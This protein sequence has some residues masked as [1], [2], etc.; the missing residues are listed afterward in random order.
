MFNG[1]DFR[2]G[3]HAEAWG[4]L[5]RGYTDR[6]LYRARTRKVLERRLAVNAS[7]FTERLNCLGKK[8]LGA[9]H[10]L[11]DERTM[12]IRYTTTVESGVDYNPKQFR[13]EVKAYLADPNGWKSEGYAFV[14]SRS[15]DVVIHL[16]SAE[17]LGQ[18]GCYDSKLSCAELGGRHM[19]LNFDRWTMGAPASKLPL[20]DYRQYMVTH[21][22]GHILGHEHVKCPG[23]GQPAPLMMQQTRGIGS[24]KPNTKLTRRDRK[25]TNALSTRSNRK[26]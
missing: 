1:L 4:E 20:A 3:G 19:R 23:S 25:K 18:V 22:M 2:F 10:F 21:E 5:T 17:T 16:T 11:Y 24:C 13:R 7:H 6:C 26:P 8:T 12:K 15:P 9:L 14:L